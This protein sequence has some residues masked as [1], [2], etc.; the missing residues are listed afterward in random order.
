MQINHSTFTNVGDAAAVL[1]MQDG[2]DVCAAKGKAEY[3]TAVNR[4][5]VLIPSEPL[6]TIPATEEALARIV[7][8]SSKRHPNPF[9]GHIATPA[10]Y[11]D[12]RR[13]VQAALR[14]A[15]GDADR[16]AV[17]NARRDGWYELLSC[18]KT[19]VEQGGAVAR[20]SLV[21]INRLATA[22]RTLDIEP[23]HLS[24]RDALDR[25][26]AI[27]LHGNQRA[28][29][30]RGLAAIER[31]RAVL[32]ELNRVLPPEP[33]GTFVEARRIRASVPEYLEAQ[34]AA[35]IAQASNKGIDENSGEPIEPRN[36]STTNRYRASF[37]HY[38]TT[39]GKAGYPV[40]AV[41]DL[42]SL[43]TGKA[44][45]AYLSAAEASVGAVD[46]IKPGSVQRYV[47]D[48]ITVAS[49]NG[50]DVSDAAR[51]SR[52]NE[53]LKRARVKGQEMGSATREFCMRLLADKRRE[54]IFANLHVLCREKA[55]AILAECGGNPAE[56]K[57]R[58]R[59]TFLAFGTIAGF[60]AIALR[61]SPDRKGAILQLKLL[62]TEPHL[63]APD[64]NF[65]EWRFW[66]PAEN[67]KTKKERPLMPITGN[68]SEV[69]ERYIK[70]VR[71]L[72]DGGRNLPWLFP[73]P[74]AA[75]RMSGQRFDTYMLEASTACGL[76]MTA[77]RFR[78]GQA[79]RLLDNSWQNLPI[80]AELLGNTPAVCGRFYA[81][82]NKQKLRRNTYEVL[83]A[84]EKE[85]SK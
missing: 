35:W 57:G 7:P 58:K 5:C 53:M 30:A 8:K 36:I 33:L 63:L 28:A 15:S 22:S 74:E 32:P 66:I 24:D 19:N 39:L 43:V 72:L 4:L 12:F 13:R 73:A 34:V 21:A 82:I 62:G 9:P 37:R 68:G 79:T 45:F 80:A 25:L 6:N 76:T 59:A 10:A 40:A 75:D 70:V 83:D 48:I 71:P 46:A 3:A 51:V 65:K 44:M 49:R 60:A 42:S 14:L 78:A 61:G 47:T 29:W 56:L 77:H 16:R 26:D 2:R 52:G 38:L 1:T 11:K 67:T 85:M 31:Y 55:E 69:I 18:L 20:V 17:L 81:F 50:A 27:S 64:R 54:K 41:N 84:R 23:W